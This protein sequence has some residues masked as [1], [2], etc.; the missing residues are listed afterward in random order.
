MQEAL[1]ISLPLWRVIIFS[2]L[3]DNPLG[4]SAIL[5]RYHRCLTDEISLMRI[6]LTELQNNPELVDTD[7]LIRSS[8]SSSESIDG[9][10]ETLR[11]ETVNDTPLILVSTE[12]EIAMN[13][14]VFSQK[15]H[16][17]CGLQTSRMASYWNLVCTK[18][19][20][21]S[22]LRSKRVIDTPKERWVEYKVMD[23]E[24]TD[25]S[26]L[27]HYDLTINDA[28]LGSLYNSLHSYFAPRF[29]QAN[30]K[31]LHVGECT[32]WHLEH[33]VGESS[34]KWFHLYSC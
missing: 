2:N 3:C 27:S 11:T 4:S 17:H 6:M 19:D 31:K 24:I 28:I 9:V 23:V 8:Q 14:S 20:S 26:H 12:Q 5:F 30:T 16:R 33:V 1:P 15:P 7:I 13:P 21:I 34:R 10:E 32:L 29:Q 25:L 22:P 18:K